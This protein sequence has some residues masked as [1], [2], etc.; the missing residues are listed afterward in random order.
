RTGTV[1]T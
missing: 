1:E